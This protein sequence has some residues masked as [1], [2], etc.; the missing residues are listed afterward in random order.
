MVG[1]NRVG[2]L[3]E[4]GLR[5]RRPWM[6]V[7]LPVY[8]L[9][10]ILL[11]YRPRLLVPVMGDALPHGILWWGLWMIIGAIGGL[12]ALSALFLAFSLLYSPVYLVANVRRILDPQAWVDRREVRFY[13]GCFVILCGLIA[14]AFL[15]PKAALA[16][17]VLLAG[18]AQSLW[19]LLV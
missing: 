5:P 6:E 11:Y 15:H 8:S 16:S 1:M 10:M 17:F 19:R 3:P 4:I 2:I 14:L 13:V 9:L 7:V 12:L 18:F